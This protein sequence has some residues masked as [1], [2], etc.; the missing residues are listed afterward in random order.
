MSAPAARDATPSIQPILAVQFVGSLGF[1]IVIPFLVYLVT[2]WGGNAFV[3]GVVGATYSFFQLIG[4]PILGR[5]SDRFGRRKILLLSQAGTLI[6][7]LVFLVAFA[8][9]AAPL[10]RIDV[11]IAGAFALTLP[12]LVVFAARAADGVTGGNIS[13]A[14]AYLADVSSDANRSAHFGR[15][16]VASNLGFVIGPGLAGVLGSTPLGEVLPVA[17]AAAIS[18]VAMALI[19]FRLPESRPRTLE[20]QPDAHHLRHVFGA[21]RKACYKV[22]AP[23]DGAWSAA[24]R[25]GVPRV[26][27]IYFLVMLGFNFFYIAFPVYAATRL[28]WSVA[29]TGTFFMV[30][31]AA[32]ALVQGPVLGR[33]AKRWSDVSLIV[34]GGVVLTASFLFFTSSAP[35]VV[36][37]G[38]ILLALGNGVM[39]PSILSVL[40]R[41]AGREHQGAVQGVAGSLGAFAS[42][43]GLIAGGALYDRVG[44]GVFVAAA[45][46]ILGSVAIGALLERPR[47][48]AGA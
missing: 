26:L 33:A 27:A 15:L 18:L 9:P 14:T 21:E 42:I 24:R 29:A 45:V 17:A 8:L 36:Y 6:S 47:A 46:T 37:A 38:A 44:P 19:V 28:A 20:R 3:Y 30:L 1:S 16:A 25:P 7:W 11:P 41:V 10:A 32:M 22:K 12:L 4:A 34:S 40:A 48:A 23:Q 31:S 5:W 43:V 13:V 2:R 39:W 35:P